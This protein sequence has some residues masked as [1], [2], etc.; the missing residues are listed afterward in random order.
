VI[1]DRL[2]A[3]NERP[4]PLIAPVIAA[5]RANRLYALTAILLAF[6]HVTYFTAFAIAI[7]DRGGGGDLQATRPPAPQRGD[8]EEPRSRAEA[9][10][11][12]WC[13]V[14]D[15][16]VARLVF[17]DEAATLDCI[18]ETLKELSERVACDE[19]I[20][21]AAE[22]LRDH[23]C[24][25]ERKAAGYLAV[26]NARE[27]LRLRAQARRFRN[28]G[29]LTA[30]IRGHARHSQWS[31]DRSAYGSDVALANQRA[32]HT[33]LLVRKFLAGDARN[34][35]DLEGDWKSY[36]VA[37]EPVFLAKGRWRLYEL[38]VRDEFSIAEV[39]LS[40][41]STPSLR[42]EVRSLGAHDELDL[43]DYLYFTI[44]TITT[45]GYGD[46]IPLSPFA[47]LLV[48]LANLFELFFIAIVFNI[49]A[50]EGAR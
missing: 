48:S 13:Y 35:H 34:R 3:A 19:S 36:G 42:A 2:A 4:S 49:V 21:V 14:D 38:P 45:T 28:S 8:D 29:P 17:R 44:Y 18:D 12:D 10:E 33:E 23:G 31:A 22:K 27:L 15:D 5:I 41:S 40:V 37:S 26:W 1:A 30:E 11:R 6:L 25:K 43:L 32:L 20:Y 50:A 16:W 7:S 24:V 39:Q 9:S 46:I 47:R